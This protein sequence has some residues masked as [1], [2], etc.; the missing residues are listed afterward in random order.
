[1]VRQVVNNSDR[2]AQLEAAAD[3]YVRRRARM[4][5]AAPAGD[6]EA[7]IHEMWEVLGELRNDADIRAEL[8]KPYRAPLWQRQAALARMA[9]AIVLT[10]MA[11]GIGGYVLSAPPAYRTA[12]GEQR[13][14]RLDD[15][16]QVTLNTATKLT[17][18]IDAGQR[19][20]ELKEGEAYFD[21]A[22]LDNNRPFTVRA[23]EAEVRVTGTRFNVRRTEDGVRV[24]VL[25]GRV[26]AGAQGRAEGRAGA[27][28]LAADQAASFDTDGVVRWRGAAQVA[29]ID[30]W[31]RGRVYFEDTPLREAVAEMNR[32]APVRMVIVTPR[33]G[34][35][36][37]SG[38][39]RAG[40][41]DTFAKAVTL[42][43]AVK[44]RKVG[45]VM[46]I[47]Q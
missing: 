15:G 28:P 45:D 9:A 25:E 7:A 38:V 10:V 18:R 46:E 3:R 37:I 20:I 1:M 27:V 23:G 21:V 14:V 24:D 34:D 36:P 42:S 44:V 26:L 31:R 11:A 35:M 16:S 6:D 29:R 32:Y 17:A 40:S 22:H 4:G 12:T 30:N 33:L 47:S 19:R 41:S 8:R 39:F 2:A 13:L 43:H 5:E